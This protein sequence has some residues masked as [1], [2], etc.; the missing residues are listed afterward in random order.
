MDDPME[1]RRF[2]AGTWGHGPGG[3]AQDDRPAEKR[4][5]VLERRAS[6]ERR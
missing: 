5:G 1:E 4:A 2:L 3:A 6:G